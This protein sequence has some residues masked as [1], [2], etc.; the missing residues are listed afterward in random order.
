MLPLIAR[1]A[2]MGT[3]VAPICWVIA[4]SSDE[5]TDEP[6]IRSRSDVFP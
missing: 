2:S 4:P 5:T 6:R 3:T 1:I